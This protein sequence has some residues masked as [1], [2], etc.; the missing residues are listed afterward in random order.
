MRKR[1]DNL[2]YWAVASLLAMILASIVAFITGRYIFACAYSALAGADA[3]LI[4][5]LVKIKPL[6]DQIYLKMGVKTK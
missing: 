5:L 4:W 6:L 2:V 1:I 3:M